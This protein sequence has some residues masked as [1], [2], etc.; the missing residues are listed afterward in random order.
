M[1][2]QVVMSEEEYNNLMDTIEQ[3]ENQNHDKGTSLLLYRG[4]FK[5]ILYLVN[6]WL[7]MSSQNIGYETSIKWI[8]E[9]LKKMIE[10]N[11]DL[12]MYLKKR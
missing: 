3:L 6:E 1:I 8:R 10:S 12:K 11:D 9:D 5:N 7:E 2:K 4:D